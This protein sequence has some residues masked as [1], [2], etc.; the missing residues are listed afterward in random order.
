MGIPD[1]DLSPRGWGRNVPRKR[2]WGS[3]RGNFFRRG[4]GDGELKP[5]VEFSVAIPTSCTHR[6]CP[7]R[8]RCLTRALHSNDTFSATPKCSVHH[9]T[10]LVYTKNLSAGRVVWSFQCSTS[11]W[12]QTHDGAALFCIT[13]KPNKKTK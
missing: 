2:S 6:T 12:N 13:L 8:H 1:G 10:C 7:V 9:Q 5:D 11:L 3:P 4:D